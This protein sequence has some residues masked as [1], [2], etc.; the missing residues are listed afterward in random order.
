MVVNVADMTS[1]ES[2]RRLAQWWIDSG[3]ELDV[4]GPYFG[5]ESLYEGFIHRL[6]QERRAREQRAGEPGPTQA[7]DLE[8]AF[9]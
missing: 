7:V 1:Y 4:D 9:A 6:D 3:G 2:G 5:S 8:L